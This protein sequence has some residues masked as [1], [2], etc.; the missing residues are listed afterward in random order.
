MAYA[1][2]IHCAECDK[3]VVYYTGDDDI[4]CLCSDCYKIGRA[5]V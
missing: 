2:Y 1:D 3:K 5:H 4:S